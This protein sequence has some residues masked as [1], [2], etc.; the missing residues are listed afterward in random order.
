MRTRRRKRPHDCVNKMTIS[1][2]PTLDRFA[3]ERVQK[4]GFASL[5]GYLQDLVRCA[6]QRELKS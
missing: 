3:R 4:E 5:S 1:L 2:P 6:M